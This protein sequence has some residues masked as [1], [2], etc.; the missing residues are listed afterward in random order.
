MTL[1]YFIS[2]V[3][4]LIGEFLE[5]RGFVEAIASET[6]VTYQRD[7]RLISLAYYVE[8][9]PRPWL[10]VDVGLVGEDQT[11]ELVGLWRALSDDQPARAY[12]T[13]TFHDE[14]SLEGV[15]ARMEGILKDHALELCNSEHELRRLLA[16]QHDE[17]ETDYLKAQR[18]SDLHR[19]RRAF[20][21]GRL[22]EAV[23]GYVLLGPDQL[24]AADRR[25]LHQARA[26][27]RTGDAGDA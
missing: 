6:R 3:R 12:T 22:E 13:W 26:G 1:P 14:P 9:L 4:R 11:H 15:L 16:M 10:A 20:E 7:D 19:A 18:T 8:D 2:T 25:R 5:R 27:L 24:T 17:A 21:E 23:D